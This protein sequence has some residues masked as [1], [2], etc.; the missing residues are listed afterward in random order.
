M[1]TTSEYVLGPTPEAVDRGYGYTMSATPNCAP[2]V[3]PTVCVY[4]RLQEPAKAMHLFITA[5]SAR[6]FAAQLV[7]AADTIDPEGASQ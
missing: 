1:T 6:E 7:A 5:A 4:T 3:A 2:A